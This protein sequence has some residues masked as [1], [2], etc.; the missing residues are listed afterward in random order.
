M[1]ELWDAYDGDFKKVEGAVLVRGE[2]IPD[3]LFHLVA[4]VIVKHADGDYLLM[5]R[6][7]RKHYGG[8]WEATAGG[9]ALKGETPYE[10]AIRELYEETGILSSDLVEVGRVNDGKHTIYIEFFCET[11][12][13]KDS[14]V[15]QE[16]ETSAY[17]WVSADQLIAMNKEEL[18]TKRMQT[19]IEELKE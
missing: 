7:P 10:C 12:C 17:K 2:E 5:Q 9:S 6:D 19:F 3:G 8:M 14:V 11:D 1:T 13:C 16:G 15:M 4:D 18:V